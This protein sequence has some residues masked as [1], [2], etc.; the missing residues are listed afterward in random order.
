MDRPHYNL[1]RWRVGTHD[2]RSV[3]QLKCSISCCLP[4][5]NIGFYSQL[6]RCNIILASLLSFWSFYHFPSYQAPS[7][8]LLPNLSHINYL[9]LNYVACHIKYE[10]ISLA[11]NIYNNPMHSYST[12][13]TLYFTSSHNVASIP[14]SLG[15]AHILMCFYFSFFQPHF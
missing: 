9:F 8:I 5:A 2:P 1:I 10:L 3:F 6:D 7:C 14:T 11:V 15:K 13:P 4:A 12:I